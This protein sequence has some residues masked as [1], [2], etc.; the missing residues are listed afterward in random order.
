M[1]AFSFDFDIDLGDFGGDGV[2]ISLDLDFLQK[3]GKEPQLPDWSNIEEM[4]ESDKFEKDMEEF[5]N[6]ID[7]MVDVDDATWE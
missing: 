5:S 1:N 6:K 4:F 7:E 2:D 3:D